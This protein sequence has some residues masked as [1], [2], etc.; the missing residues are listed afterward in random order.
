MKLFVPL[1]SIAAIVALS[2]S[3]CGT[4]P[5]G[6]LTTGKYD[7]AAWDSLHGVAS[8]LDTL[9]K[10]GKLRGSAAVSAKLELDKATAALTAADAAYHAGNGASAAQNVA[11]ATALIGEL[12]SIATA[13]KGP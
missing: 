10:A 5:A 8:T 1:A 3:A 11:T 13:A 7:A 9:A 2:V 6:D 4:T 12:A